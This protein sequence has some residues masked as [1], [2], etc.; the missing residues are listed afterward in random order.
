MCLSLIPLAGIFN[1]TFIELFPDLP[2]SD[3]P[4]TPLAMHQS[5]DSSMYWI[6]GQEG[7][8]VKVSAKC[9]FFAMVGMI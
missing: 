7:M 1:G 4:D 9:F 2:D 5:P 3:I 6:S 8:L